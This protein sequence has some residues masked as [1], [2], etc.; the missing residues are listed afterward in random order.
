MD[1]GGRRMSW[2]GWGWED[3]ALDAGAAE[4]VGATLASML[5]VDAPRARPAVDLSGVSLP[6]PRFAPPV[7]LRVL[8]SDDRRSRAAH[9]QGKSFRDV[10]RAH[11]GAIEHP[12][13]L[14]AA[15][16]GEDDV[17]AL[18]EWCTAANIA[19][20]PY[21]G[22]SSVVG[23]VE[24]D[25]G[26]G[27]AGTVSVDLRALG[28]V[29]DVDKQSRAVRTQAGILGP[30]LEDALRPHGLTLRHF[31]QSFEFSSVGGWLATRS[32]GHYA[33]LHTHIDDF[34]ESLRAITP[35]GVIE[36]R[37][38]PASGAGPS[39]DRLLLGS[40]G[41]LGVITEAWLRVQERP[42]FR[43]SASV[44]F[45]LFGDGAAAARA[46]AQSGMHPSNCRLLD[47]TEALIS[48]AGDGSTALLL[49]GFESADH[50]V[51]A[52]ITRALELCADHGGEQPA[53]VRTS[54]G[55]SAEGS[56]DD[57]AS[58]W[59]SAFLRAPYMR[60]ALVTLGWISETFESAI[61]WDRF[62]S[63]HGAVT[64]A[65]REALTDACG[66]G[67]LSC[68]FTHVY[69]DGCAPYYTVIAPGRPG[70]SISQWQQIKRA[71]SEAILANGGTIT[72]HHAV[73]RD[74]RPWYDRQRPDLFAAALQAAKRQLDPASIL[75]PGVLI[76][77]RP[78]RG[79]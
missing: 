3:A 72:H 14:V 35:R 63:L 39:A 33:T 45:A 46:L 47:A 20:I 2:W 12:P 19:A 57:G 77:P 59:R 62:A 21:G 44:R 18:L 53:T 31:P 10:V 13:D 17:G 73:G 48:G 11:A 75:N 68:R 51:E 1:Q 60:D 27:Y 34:V 50:D 7:A 70:S 65:T 76:D 64:T 37:R 36:T 40:E 28:A 22:G 69:P 66:T 41:I 61:T 8:C 49:V 24:P 30:A 9:A 16:R 71:A 78:V 29:L 42:R 74:H 5:G 54:S 6:P 32:G 4:A 38:L 55:E 23:G 79:S 52:M 56:G 67:L 15:P 26:D 43:A 58:R 25:V